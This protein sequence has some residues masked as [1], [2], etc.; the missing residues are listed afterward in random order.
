M[1]DFC[2]RVICAQV[3][4]NASTH[5]YC[6]ELELVRT[7]CWWLKDRPGGFLGFLSQEAQAEQ[8]EPCYFLGACWPCSLGFH[9]SVS[10]V[11]GRQ[12]L[13]S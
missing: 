10:Q 2:L 12:A 4:R 5:S 13:L 11:P 1:A 3:Q 8:G 9:P 6:L 7:I